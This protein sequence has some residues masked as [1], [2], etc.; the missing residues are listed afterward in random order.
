MAKDFYQVLGVERSADEKAIKTAYRRLAR[1]HHPDLN[2]GSEEA[3]ARFKEVSEAYAVLSDPEKRKQYDRFGPAWKDVQPGGGSGGGQDFDFGAGGGIGDIFSAFFG[4]GAGDFSGFRVEAQPRDVEHA[5]ELTLEEIDQGVRRQLTY[6]VEQPC[7]RC[8]GTGRVTLLGGGQGIC[9]EC[10]GQCESKERRTTEV[11]I[12][13]GIHEGKKLRVPGGGAA[14]SRGKKGDLYVLIK[15]K[16]HPI[17]TRDGDDLTATVD[18]PYVDA[19]LGGEIEAPTL[20][21]SGTVTLPPGSQ[22]GQRIRL[23]ERGLA[24]M[25]GGRGDLYIRLRIVTPKNPSAEEIALLQQ[26]RAMGEGR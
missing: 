19:I 24:K 26:I 3:E 25:G 23:K 9:P 16:P 6:Q 10:L 14:G 5:V 12:P 4:G 22:T 20:R 7:S 21:T 18:V 8:Q 11:K 13:A 15:I 1:K 2:P 17:F